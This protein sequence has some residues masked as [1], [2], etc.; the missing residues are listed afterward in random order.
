M[1]NGEHGVVRSIRFFVTFLGKVQSWP[2]GW[3]LEDGIVS[4]FGSKYVVVVV[5][6]L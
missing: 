4:G 5:D 1:S 2:L 3:T 6:D